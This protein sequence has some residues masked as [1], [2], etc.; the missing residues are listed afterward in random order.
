MFVLCGKKS[1]SGVSL[2]DQQP[3]SCKFDVSLLITVG[4]KTLVDGQGLDY[5]RLESIAYER[6]I[7]NEVSSKGYST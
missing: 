2:I 3:I 7:T 4:V 1:C 6:K 5:G